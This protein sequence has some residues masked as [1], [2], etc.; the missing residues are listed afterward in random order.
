M[1]ATLTEEMRFNENLSELGVAY[2]E[3]GVDYKLYKFISA[4][5][6]YRYIQKKQ[7]DNFYSLRHR[8]NIDLSLKYKIKMVNVSLRERFQTQYADVNT[9]ETGSVPQRYLRNKLTLKYNL[10]K[11]YTPF[12]YSELFLQL[13]N[14]EGNEIDNVRYAAGF[15]YEINKLMNLEFYYMINKKIHVSD[16]LTEYITGID[17]TYSF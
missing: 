13:N 11:K 10:G 6:S 14:P 8:Y 7:V 9:S 1:A 12:I 5:V 17:F 3:L 16:P 2:T 4:G 15:E